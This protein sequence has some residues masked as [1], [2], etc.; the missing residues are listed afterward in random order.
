MLLRHGARDKDGQENIRVTVW[1]VDWA[2][3]KASSPSFHSVVIKYCSHRHAVD[4]DDHFL[5]VCVC[6]RHQM[7]RFLLL[8]PLFDR[9]GISNKTPLSPFSFFFSDHYPVVVSSFPPPSNSSTPIST[10]VQFS[11]FARTVPAR[12]CQYNELECIARTDAHHVTSETRCYPPN[13]VESKWGH[14]WEY[15]RENPA[16]W[17]ITVVAFIIVIGLLVRTLERKES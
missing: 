14:F 11:S 16:V 4:D 1:D 7:L 13:A 9:R 17:V 12:R 5:H 8:P 6:G 2:K 10:T 15:M 3:R